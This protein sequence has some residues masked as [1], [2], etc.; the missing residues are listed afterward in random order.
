MALRRQGLKPGQRPAAQVHGRTAARQVH[1][2]HIAPPDATPDSRAKR[3]GAGLLGGESLGVGRDY[4]LLILGA[5]PGLGA[6]G[7]RE[8]ALEEP[9]TMALDDLRDPSHVDQVR[10]NADDH[11]LLARFA[12]KAGAGFL[13]PRSIAARIVRTV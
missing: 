3:L 10:A 11:A 2:P 6:L 4:H 1:H 12:L 8:D 5:T 7:F 13:R 9:I